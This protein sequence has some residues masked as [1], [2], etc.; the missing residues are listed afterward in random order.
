MFAFER[1]NTHYVLRP[2]VTAPVMRSYLQHHLGQ[3]GGVQKLFYIGP[4]FRAE[5]PQKGRYR[6]FHQ[7]GVE[8]IGAEGALADVE[9]ISVMMDVY[10]K[11]GVLDTTLR[12]NSLGDE[13]SRL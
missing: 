8:L 9:V 11:M 12:L 3:K 4:C 7:F 13:E 10:K 6:Q 2:E 1:G 5:R